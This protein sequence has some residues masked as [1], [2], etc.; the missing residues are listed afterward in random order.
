MKNICILVLIIFAPCLTANT[1]AHSKSYA[2]LTENEK[3]NF[4][5]GKIDEITEKISGR[6]YCFKWDFKLQV[7]KYVEAYS[8]RVGNNRKR[9]IFAE[10]INF[11]L[12]RGSDS[13]PAINKAF[14]KNGGA[15]IH[16]D[17][18]SQYAAVEYRRLLY[19][20]G[21]RQS[22]SAKG[23]CYDNAQAESFFSRFKAELVEGGSFESVEQARSETFSYIEGYYNRIRRH[24]S[25]DYLSPLEFEK[26]LKIKNQ[27]SRESFVSCFS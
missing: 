8:K 5:V 21:L 27:R 17:R 12:R 20:H 2:D 15:I 7:S 14:D 23:N 6:K 3:A 24:S 9:G 26:Q 25:L 11:V 10:D 16:T 1:Q 13:A 18:G 4:V 22:M 19:I